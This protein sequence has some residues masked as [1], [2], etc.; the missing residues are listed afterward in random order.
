[1]VIKTQKQQF[2]K[3]EWVSLS[4]NTAKLFYFNKETGLR[5]S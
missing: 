4:L 2:S 5:V 3:G 1:M